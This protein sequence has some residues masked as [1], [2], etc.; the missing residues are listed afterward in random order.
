VRVLL[1]TRALLWW[2]TDDPALTRA[3]RRVIGQTSNTVLVSAATAWEIATNVRLGKLPT[4]AD[5]VA[6]FTGQMARE[7]FELLAVS[8]EHGIRGGLLPGPCKDPFDRMLIAQCQ[9]DGLPIVS[10]ETP[11]DA[12]GVRRLW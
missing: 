6:D 2:L 9:A 4:A 1:D 11:F 12:Y 3:A 7:G 10:R 8:A 5:L